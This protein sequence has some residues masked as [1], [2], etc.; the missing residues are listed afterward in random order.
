[1]PTTWGRMKKDE[2][3]HGR[4]DMK[5]SHALKCSPRH[6]EGGERERGERE[7]EKGEREVRRVR[8]GG[9]CRKMDA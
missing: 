5:N 6:R 1:M 3:D 2:E 4:K 9:R 7:R 8:E